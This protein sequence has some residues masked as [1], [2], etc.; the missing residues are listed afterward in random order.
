MFALTNHGGVYLSDDS[1]VNWIEENNGLESLSTY[2]ILSI[3]D[4]GS[5]QLFINTY[6]GLYN[7]PS[8]LVGDYNNDLIVNVLDIVMLVN[9]ILVPVESSDYEL[10]AGDLNGDGLINV[11]D[12]VLVVN[13]IIGSN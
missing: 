4:N 11:L 3:S 10:W 12:I 1:G 6:S 5:E 13:L 9:A 2:D 7:A 8:A